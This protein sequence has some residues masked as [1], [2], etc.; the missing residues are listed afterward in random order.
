[1]FIVGVLVASATGVGALLAQS[2]GSD[3]DEPA[4]SAVR[5]FAPPTRLTM[6]SDPSPIDTMAGSLVL[7]S[8]PVLVRPASIDRATGT[9][10]VTIKRGEAPLFRPRPA[11]EADSNADHYQ[12]A[13]QLQ[14]ELARVGCYSGLVDGDW[15]GA[16]RRAMQSFLD[17]VNA[18]LPVDDPAP[19]LIALVGNHAANV[20]SDTCMTSDVVGR[21]GR[22]IPTALV[23][24]KK[25]TAS[26]IVSAP[27]A[28]TPVAATADSQWK[29][30]VV[31][32]A[33]RDADPAAPLEQLPGRMALGV[34]T[35]G[36]TTEPGTVVRPV[37]PSPPPRQRAQKSKA[38]MRDVFPDIYAGR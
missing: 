33:M 18:V 10:V 19:V 15:G 1:M 27:A 29:T 9:A 25:G 30:E 22:C 7:V 26:R 23:A 34:T 12:R 36:E 37:R 17:R 3:T 14:R 24:E 35:S 2:V 38:W 32:D 16:S 28:V 31:A 11:S 8:E 4:G 6:P 5:T 13:R 20:C 21:D